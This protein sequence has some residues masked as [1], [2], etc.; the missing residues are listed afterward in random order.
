[1]C[2]CTLRIRLGSRIIHFREISSKITN[3]VNFGTSFKFGFL[4]DGLR[5]NLLVF[6]AALNK[7]LQ[8][9]STKGTPPFDV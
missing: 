9:R 3:V 2:F 4:E 8:F 1:M 7:V 5:N 6:R